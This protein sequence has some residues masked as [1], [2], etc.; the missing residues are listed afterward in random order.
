MD[1]KGFDDDDEWT[2]SPR[3]WGMEEELNY[4][5]EP[6]FDIPKP[7]NAVFVIRYQNQDYEFPEK[8]LIANFDYFFYFFAKNPVKFQD[9]QQHSSE[10]KEPYELKLDQT[11]DAKLQ[12]PDLMLWLQWFL[13]PVKSVQFLCEQITDWY[14]MYRILDFLQF[15]QPAQDRLYECLNSEWGYL[16]QTAPWPQP[17]QF[18]SMFLVR[19]RLQMLV[20]LKPP[21]QNHDS[22]VTFVALGSGLM[23]WAQD[24]PNVWSYAMLCE[25][26]QEWTRV[27]K[28]PFYWN[29]MDPLVQHHFNA[30]QLLPDQQEE[31]KLSEK[32]RSPHVGKRIWVPDMLHFVKNLQDFLG[33]EMYQNLYYQLKPNHL[34][35]TQCWDVLF[36]PWVRQRGRERLPFSASDSVGSL[37]F[38]GIH[39]VGQ[40]RPTFDGAIVRSIYLRGHAEHHTVMVVPGAS[41]NVIFHEQSESTYCGMYFDGD[42][43][44]CDMATLMNITSLY[45]KPGPIS[46]NMLLRTYGFTV[47]EETDKSHSDIQKQVV[48]LSHCFLSSSASEEE[49]YRTKYTL[50]EI[51]SR[52]QRRVNHF[53]KNTAF[54]GLCDHLSH[55]II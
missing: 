20:A 27:R 48:F 13:N 1:V 22:H 11:L 32:D 24:E 37:A 4:S 6:C 52:E 54:H 36:E 15:R 34:V 18:W 3:G 2:S 25:A 5:P 53:L 30:F 8:H 41:K 31:D 47:P 10:Q 44:W 35:L 29:L 38:H 43:V 45:C 46:T 16:R 12:H 55:A 23:Q 28:Q 21:R 9:Q 19:R 39:L 49:R 17:R 51:C 50:N 40:K 26:L 33:A 14:V 7:V 42:A